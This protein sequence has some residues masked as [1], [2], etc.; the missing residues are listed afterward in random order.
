MSRDT[1]N[2]DGLTLHEWRLV[3]DS[4]GGLISTYNEILRSLSTEPGGSCDNLQSL[5]PK[6]HRDI[7]HLAMAIDHHARSTGRREEDLLPRLK[8]PSPD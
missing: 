7:A 2:T 4:L 5:I 6:L 1:E 3:D 8:A